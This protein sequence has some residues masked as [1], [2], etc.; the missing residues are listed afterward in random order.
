MILSKFNTKRGIMKH[1]TKIGLVF[2]TIITVS[3]FAFS[4]KSSEAGKIKFKLGSVGIIR[5]NTKLTTVKI[6]DPL[7]LGD[8]IET[9]T[10]SRAELILNDGTVIK[11]NENTI[12]KIEKLTDPN[13]KESRRSFALTA[14]SVWL[15][16]K[17]LF[18]TTDEFSIKTPTAVAAVRGTEFQMSLESNNDMKVV[19]KEGVVD[20]GESDILR[21]FDS[22]ADWLKENEAAYESWKNKNSG[23]EFFEQEYKAYKEFKN[24]QNDDFEAFKR[25][26]TPVA[27]KSEWVKSVGA[28]EMIIITGDKRV[29]RKFNDD[30]LIK[31]FGTKFDEEKEL[32]N[33]NKN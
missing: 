11:V 24:M 29:L 21:D 26:E 27:K 20:C 15:K 30:D 14:G 9:K 31:G 33:E 1:I 18:G 7:F 16:V 19:V 13:N 3:F 22:F 28:G 4:P 2:L 17:K 8:I 23:E 10:E 25:G 6:N 5:S 12:F 32:D